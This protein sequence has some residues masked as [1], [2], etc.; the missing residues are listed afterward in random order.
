MIKSLLDTL[1]KVVTSSAPAATTTRRHL[2]TRM[3]LKPV[4]TVQHPKK[5]QKT[6]STQ[7]NQKNGAA[8][9]STPLKETTN[10]GRRIE[11]GSTQFPDSVDR[12]EEEEVETNQEVTI[13]ISS[14]IFFSMVCICRIPAACPAR[15]SQQNS[16][17]HFRGRF[18][19][20]HGPPC[21]YKSFA[22]SP[23]TR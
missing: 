10:R 9:P 14:K 12:Q 1:A 21:P 16:E 20:S 2:R 22:M 13:S 3:S 11:P 7:G 8:A 5:M 18:R 4:A 23:R 6:S 15:S 17:A 19:S